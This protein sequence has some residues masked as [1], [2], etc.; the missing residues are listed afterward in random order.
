MWLVLET[1]PIPWLG[2]CPPKGD[3]GEEAKGEH[4]DPSG[5]YGVVP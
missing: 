1:T 5:E 3:G 2:D 4:G